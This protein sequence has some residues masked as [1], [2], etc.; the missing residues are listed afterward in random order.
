MSE[1]LT[2]EQFLR[3]VHEHQL[4][5]LREDGVYRHLRFSKPGSFD[6]HFELVTWPG[7]LA[8]VGD[9]GAFTF[10]RM[11]DMLDF[12][13]RD[14][15]KLFRIDMRYWAEKCEAEGARGEGLRKWDPARFRREITSLRRSLLVEHGRSWTSEQRQDFWDD[16]GNLLLD[17]EHEHDAVSALQG[18]SHEDPETRRRIRIDT[19]DFPACQTYTLRFRWCCY[20]LAWGI[21]KY[22]EA[23][24]VVLGGAAA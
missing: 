15:D 9:M 1:H 23:K 6:R 10:T 13:R 14:P 12:F 7:Y 19:T 11:R 8:Y 22:D 16:I 20:A 21:N 5:I 18:W 17:A 2:P 4:T 3:D 24:Q